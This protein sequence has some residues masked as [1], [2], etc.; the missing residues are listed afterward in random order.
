MSRDLDDFLRRAAERRAQ[1]QQQ[2]REPVVN[3]HTA[4]AHAPPS[5]PVPQAPSPAPRY[6]PRPTPPTP[7]T[8][9]LLT[10]EDPA[11]H[12][13]D[14]RMSQ[15]LHASF[16]HQLGDIAAPAKTVTAASS[17]A[18]ASGASPE[19]TTTS[20]SPFVDDLVAMLRQ[21][22]SAATAVI[23]RE[24]LERPEHRW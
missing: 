19:A 13:A 3:P 9:I 16:D 18:S 7:E 14:E 1:K 8:P 11:V 4:S 23:L 22:R 12:Q 2:R 10:S 5:R 6:Q 24:I 21:P 17:S 15:H 20:G